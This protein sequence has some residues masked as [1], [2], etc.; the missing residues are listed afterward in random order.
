[1]R[2][3][4]AK[5]INLRKLLMGRFPVVVATRE[6]EYFWTP[7]EL[8]SSMLLLRASNGEKGIVEVALGTPCVIP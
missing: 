2:E 5:M 1:M 4:A 8:R 6:D 7:T 3:E